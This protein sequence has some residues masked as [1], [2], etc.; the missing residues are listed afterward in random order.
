M[1]LSYPLSTPL[2][3][4]LQSPSSSVLTS[5]ERTAAAGRASQHAMSDVVL[6]AHEVVRHLFPDDQER[7][8]FLQRLSRDW[9]N[10]DYHVSLWLYVPLIPDP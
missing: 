2:I 10:P 1:I 8:Q 7:E 9:Y 3:L 4:L 5:D 6:G